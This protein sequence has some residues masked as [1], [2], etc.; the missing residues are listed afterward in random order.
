MKETTLYGFDSLCNDPKKELSTSSKAVINSIL[1]LTGLRLKS[2]SKSL[3][4][5][6]SYMLPTREL[7]SR[8]LRDISLCRGC[9]IKL[10]ILI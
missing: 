8:I 3:S 2:Q 6:D 9:I 10:I 1:I 4:S 7:P 5:H